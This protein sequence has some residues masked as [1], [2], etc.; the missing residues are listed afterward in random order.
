MLASFPQ[1]NQGGDAP[2]FTLKD[3][4]GDVNSILDFR[5]KYLYLTFYKSSSTASLSEMEIIPA[6]YKQY[7]KKINFVSICED[8]S[9]DEFVNF[10]KKNKALNWTFLYDEG[11]RILNLYDVKTLPEYFLITP[12]G[13]FLMSPAD[14]PS[15]GI[16]NTFDNLVKPK[17]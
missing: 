7:G 13:K 16:E 11:H 3:S 8:D 2:E 17:K 5:N 12:R 14:G 6:L 10:L 1:V 4:K 9:R 15:H